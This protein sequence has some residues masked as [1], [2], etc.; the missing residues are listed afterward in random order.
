VSLCV[1]GPAAGGGDGRAVRRLHDGRVRR[2]GKGRARYPWC[3]C[4]GG[5]NG[6]N[7]RARLQRPR[8]AAPA[9]CTRPHQ[10]R[11]PQLSRQPHTRLSGGAQSDK[12]CGVHAGCMT[13]RTLV[14]V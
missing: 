3:F 2:N 6:G 5:V 7:C 14:V 9:L 12:L 10:S 11:R 13:S 8:G 1:A 4:Y